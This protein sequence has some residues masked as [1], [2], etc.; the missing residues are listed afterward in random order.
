MSPAASIAAPTL[1]DWPRDEAPHD[2]LPWEIWWVTCT[3]DAGQRRLGV[4]VIF[5]HLGGGMYS[6]AT[7]VADLASE[8]GRNGMHLAEPDHVTAAADRLDIQ[9]EAA[10]FCG[11]FDSEYRLRGR[12]DDETTFDL[13]LRPTQPVLFN[14]GSGVFPF[15]AGS[16]SQYS[17]GALAVSGSVGLEGATVEVEGTGWYDRQWGSPDGSLEDAF[18]MFTWFGLCLDS[19][20]VISL[21]DTSSRSK[22]GHTWATIVRPDGTHIIAAAEPAARGAGAN[23]EVAHGRQVPRS[24][25]LRIPALRGE[26]TV[27]QR[28]LNNLAEFFF[29]TGALEVTG[30]FD[31]AAVTGYGYCDLVGWPEPA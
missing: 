3:L 30:S 7:A 24:W 18:S 20:D 2:G 6:V 8:S 23:F 27:T 1:L 11:T 17:I 25:T 21:W 5:I 16:T 26:L 22:G 13:V 28:A 10:S 19:G 4:Q 9:T 29:H 12:V 31:G 14:G 15:G